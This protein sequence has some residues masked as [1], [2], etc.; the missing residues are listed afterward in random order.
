MKSRV[1]LHHEEFENRAR[2]KS[3]QRRTVWLCC[4]THT[5]PIGIATTGS[6]TALSTSVFCSNATH[7][8][9]GADSPGGKV[10]QT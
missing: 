10:D 3:L 2:A 8:N 1:L 4:K 7:S 5:H 6:K 9:H